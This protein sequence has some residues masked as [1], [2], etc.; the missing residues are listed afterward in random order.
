MK[1]LLLG[2]GKMGKEIEA[3]LLRRGHE[4]VARIDP[5]L[6]TPEL[7]EDTK[8]SAEVAF[9]FTTPQSALA[10]IRRAL[11]LDLRLVV[12]TTGWHS[13]LTEVRPWVEKHKG[14]LVYASN[15]SPGLVIF[16]EVVREAARRYAQLGDYDV[17]LMERHHGG[18]KD[19]PSGT[20]RTL[21]EEVLKEEKRKVRVVTGAPEP[22]GLHITS[23]RGGSSVGDHSV[24]FDAEG[25]E[26]ELAHRARS[27]RAFAAGAVRAGEW[28]RT[29]RG[30]YE[31]SE[32]IKD[33][34]T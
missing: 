9:E 13:E 24:F 4:V 34:G 8:G 23:V 6:G 11:E 5:V 18:K 29:R 33:L 10:N 12:G 3:E 31:F 32:I 25:E 22:G 27:R 1:A 20:A 17:Y 15:F 21:A 19:S 26:V 30:L 14:G 28:I 7:T 16:R 2:Y